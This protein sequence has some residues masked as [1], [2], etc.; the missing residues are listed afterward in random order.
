M[1]Y[2]LFTDIADIDLTEALATVGPQRRKH[3]LRYR[4]E[5]DQR[6]SVAAF[7]LLQR[8]LTRHYGI[9]ETPVLAFEANGKPFLADHP[10]IFFNLSHCQE[11]V[12]CVVGDVRV[13]IDVESLSSYDVSLLPSTMNDD[14]QQLILRSPDPRTSFVRLWT[15]K[16]SLLK[17]TGAGISSD[18]RNILNGYDAS[19]EAFRFHTTVYPQ[20]VCTVCQESAIKQQHEG[21]VFHS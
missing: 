21:A 16:E 11:A 8:L 15:M 12:A 7:Q 19:S 18:M 3:A 13:G 9:S 1:N 20:F 10:D 14:E 6:L 4:R 5:H 2:E 17:M